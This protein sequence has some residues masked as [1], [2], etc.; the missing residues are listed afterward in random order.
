MGFR[1]LGSVIR[2]AGLVTLIVLVLIGLEYAQRGKRG[3]AD[4][5][6]EARPL[7]RRRLGRFGG[8]IA[9]LCCGIPLTTGF[10]FP[11][12]KLGQWSLLNLRD[13]FPS[14]F[15]AML[16]RSV[17]LATFAALLVVAVG[18]LLAFTARGCRSRS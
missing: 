1:W 17:A 11:A 3:F 9:V 8:G 15:M 5:R 2:L 16:G 7:E 14:H 18:L 4:A 10:L 13:S 6:T 12:W